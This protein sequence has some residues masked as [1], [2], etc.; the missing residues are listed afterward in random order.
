[1]CQ[2]LMLS[3]GVTLPID[4][5]ELTCDINKHGFGLAWVDN[6]ELKIHRSVKQPNDP[7]EINRLLIDTIK[8]K[9]FLH[10]RHATVGNVNMENSHPFVLLQKGKGSPKPILCMMHN[11]TLSN[12]TPPQGDTVTSDTLLFARTMAGPLASRVQAYSGKSVLA[13]PIFRRR[14][15]F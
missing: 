5:L 2:V 8:F 10:L 6:G 7:D 3:A 12:Y 14:P 13:D 1:M 4:K 11:G 9:R 15:F